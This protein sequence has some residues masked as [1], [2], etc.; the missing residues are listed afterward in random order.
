[1][2]K[3]MKSQNVPNVRKP[4]AVITPAFSRQKK[5]PQNPL[6]SLVIARENGKNKQDHD[7]YPSIK[8]SLE[9]C[10]NLG[11]SELVKFIIAQNREAYRELFRRYEKKLFSYV[12]HM[13][14]NREETEDLLQDIFV[15][16]YRSIGKFDTERK[17]S[18][19]IYRI[20]HNETVNFLKRK[21]RKHFISWEDITTSK[22]K[23]E[24]SVTEDFINDIW[25]HKEIT[26]EID[27]AL[28][29]I[30]EKYRRV[31]F[32]RYFS[33]YSYEKIALIIKKP[34]NT[35]GTLINRA[36][37][38]LLD[39]VRKNEFERNKGKKRSRSKGA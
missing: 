31:L 38:K 11:D 24:A 6:L 30:P 15:K 26:K 28:G 12:Y 8:D 35:V 2:P 4:I 37:K 18:S 19:W 32:L 17:F 20:A 39:V 5:S 23:L 22:D 29:E 16:T 14:K 1:M 3:K 10:Q 33:E 25:V 21:S 34:I 13:V 27:Q 36:K 9:D 7:R